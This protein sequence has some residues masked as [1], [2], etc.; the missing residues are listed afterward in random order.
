LKFHGNFNDGTIGIYADKKYMD[1]ASGTV[2]T[3]IADNKTILSEEV[4][5]KDPQEYVGSI[6]SGTKDISIKVNEGGW[7]QYGR[8]EI[9]QKGGKT[10]DLY[11][12]D[13]FSADYN[14]EMPV[15][16]VDD[17]GNVTTTDKNLAV[18]FNYIYENDIRRNAELA[19]K[20]NVGF[21]LLEWGP[22]GTIS[23]DSRYKY[24]GMMLAGFSKLGLGWCHQSL[25]RQDSILLTKNDFYSNFKGN[26][27]NGKYTPLQSDSRYYVNTKL[28]ALY[29]QYTKK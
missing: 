13:L 15:L 4:K 23:D 24:E 19:Q 27:A 25:L 16:N 2:I 22:F 12:H 6:P 8:I 3:I 1:P 26:T 28:L 10:I 17:N 29:K 18:D 9:K 7:L 14:A 21:M 11:P 20:Y 5:G